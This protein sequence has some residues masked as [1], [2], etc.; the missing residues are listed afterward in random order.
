MSRA[1]LIGVQKCGLDMAK[2]VVGRDLG[3]HGAV[4]YC[5]L[6]QKMMSMPPA[7]SREDLP[8]TAEP[9]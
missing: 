6:K 4:R 1:P 7:T 5:L 2:D 3:L 9:P 8:S